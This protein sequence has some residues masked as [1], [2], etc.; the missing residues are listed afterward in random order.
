MGFFRFLS[1]NARWLFA[2]FVMTFASS[3]GQTYFISLFSGNI[4]AEFGLSHGDFGAAYMAATLASAVTLLW[5]GKLADRPRLDLIAAAMVGGL[6]LTSFAM[7]Q[8]QHIIALV[9][10]LYGLRLFGQGMLTHISLTAMA[11]WYNQQRGRAISIAGLGHPAGEAIFPPIAVILVVLIGWRETWMVA[12]LVLAFAALPVSFALLRQ[13]RTPQSQLP[14]SPG[15]QSGDWTR[16]RVLRD[17]LFY[18]LMPGLMA[19]SFIVTGVFFHQVH[20][21]DVKGWQLTHF[22]AGYPVFAATTVVSSLL[23]GGAIDRWSAI[24]VLPVFLLPMAFGLLVLAST[25]DP[26]LALIYFALTGLSAG[27]GT[28][29]ISALW[30]ELYG[31]SH[32]GAIRSVVVS[33]GVAASALAPGLLGWL[34]DRGVGIE[35]QLMV[36]A[37]YTFAAAGLFA[38]MMKVLAGRAY[39]LRV[40]AP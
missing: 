12:A 13:K 19:M 8:A 11:R 14:Q 27:S 38:L 31:V 15:V 40:Q 23:A 29:V 24:R 22:A 20:L 37:I 32:L 3:F 6:A 26:Y 28:T 16:A 10:V 9:V 35:Q 5:L 18:A 1:A 17:P 36:M 4:R 2:G 39:A 30:A 25:P 34:I 33:A 7:S 21:V